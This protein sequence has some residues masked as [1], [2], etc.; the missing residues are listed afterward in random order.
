MRSSSPSRTP[1]LQLAAEQPSIGE[2]WIS[3]K[4]IPPPPK[5]ETPHPKAKKPQQDGRRGEIKFTIRD[6]WKVQTKPGAD[7]GSD[8]ELFIAKFRLK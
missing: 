2:C 7:C 3:P 6:A 5:K 4:K 8:H 1:K